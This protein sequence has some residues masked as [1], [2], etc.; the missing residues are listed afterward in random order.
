MSS[1]KMYYCDICD[2][3]LKE[4][5]VFQFHIGAYGYLL[6]TS[7]NKDLCYEHFQMTLRNLQGAF[8]YFATTTLN[9]LDERIYKRGG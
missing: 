5:E 6:N 4:E 8:H 1:I 9:V 3:P 2:A 7:Y